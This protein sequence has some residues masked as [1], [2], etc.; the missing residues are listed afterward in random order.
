MRVTSHP[1]QS[2]PHS[3]PQDPWASAGSPA[4]PALPGLPGSGPPPGHR[5]R[6]GSTAVTLALV[7]CTA[8]LLG[9][10]FFLAGVFGSGTVLWLG[11]LAMVPLALCL[12]GLRWVDRWDP[13]PRALLA[14][15]LLWG[16]GASVAGALL[17]GD[18][19]M[20]LF[21]DPAGRVDLDLFGAVVQAPIVE[22]L[23][24]GAGVLLIFWINRSHFDG[25]IDGIVYGGIVGA[26][27]A[28]TENILYFASSYVDPGAPGELVSVF[29]L[30][31]LFSP[32]AH[33]MFTAWTGFALGLCA[34]RG[35]RGRWPLYLVLG[36]LPAMVGHFLWNGGVGIFFDNFLSFYFVLQ[37]PLFVA[38]IVAVALL[39]RG[40]RKLV[41]QRLDEYRAGGW[42]TA[43]EVQMF[44]TRAGRRNARRWAAGIGRSRQMKEFTTTAMNLAAVRQRIVAGHPA[45]T[46]FARELALLHKSHM[47]RAQLLALA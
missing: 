12:L 46:D 16:A 45:G 31:G 17:V 33:V 14:L 47:Q 20:E 42:F 21:F 22:E 38:S 1:P 10:G 28:F 40:E 44:A 19:F 13:E 7:A 39:Q 18:V 23:A 25:P 34:A 43:A 36:L 8:V 6:S 32:F 30:R 35:K 4:S 5:R 37:V 29:V 26:G 11:A 41:E 9:V 2:S 15:G 3:A 24:K 27:F